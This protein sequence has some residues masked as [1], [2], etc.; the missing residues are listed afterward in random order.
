MIF[1]PDELMNDALKEVMNESK[2][3]LCKELEMRLEE[4]FLKDVGLKELKATPSDIKS[5]WFANDSRITMSYIRKTLKEEM[6]LEPSNPIH[7]TQH[8]YGAITGAYPTTT[9]RCFIFKRELLVSNEAESNKNIEKSE[10]SFLYENNE[11][12]LF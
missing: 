6:G 8:L 11:K 10:S 2:S 1:A 4:F 7:Y 3:S 12:D 9:G 5:N